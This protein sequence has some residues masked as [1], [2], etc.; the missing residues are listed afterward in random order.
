MHEVGITGEADSKARRV[1]DLMAAW[2]G[3]YQARGAGARRLRAVPLPLHPQLL[4]GHL[5]RDRLG[6]VRERRPNQGHAHRGHRAG[7]SRNA[8]ADAQ[9][10][11]RA[12]GGETGCSSR[13]GATCIAS[14][15]V[16]LWP[17]CR[18]LANASSSPTIRSAAAANSLMKT[19]HASTDLRHRAS[20]G[21][22]ARHV[23]DLSDLD[24]N[25]FVLLGGQD[26]WLN[27]STFLDQVPLWLEG[28]YLEMP[29]RPET[30][31]ARFRYVTEL[32]SMS[33]AAR[34]NTGRARSCNCL[35]TALWRPDFTPLLRVYTRYRRRQL[36]RQD[37]VDVAAPGAAKTIGE[38]Q[39]HAFRPRAW[40]C[41]HRRRLGLSGRRAAAR[42]RGDV[43]GV[44][45]ADLPKAQ[46]LL[47]ARHH[48]LLRADL[49]ERPRASPSI[50]RAPA[51]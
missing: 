50:S 2:D 40:L 11:A 17:S 18:L 23:S 22:N 3:Q 32:G 30:V 14:S 47:V 42:L 1:F 24:R 48:P 15:C 10:V 8:D 46:R 29:L 44:L 5:R 49:R 12:G 19:A 37:P 9:P 13:P 36:G 25:W 33:V 45:E 35:R 31:R 16:I 38:G 34:S 7:G 21:A 51:T 4:R 39:G 43:G 28:R 41:R 6:G 26:G 27:S 20:Y